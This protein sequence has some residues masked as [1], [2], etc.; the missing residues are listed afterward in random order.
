[1]KR[2]AAGTYHSVALKSDGTLAAW[3]D[4]SSGECNVP[5]GNNYVAVA[6][7]AYHSIALKSD[8]SLA[9]WGDNSLGECNV[10]GGNDYV[11][12]AVGDVHSVA[13]KTDGTLVA[14]GINLDGQCNVPGGNNYVAVAAAKSSCVALKTDGTLAAWGDNSLGQC[15][16]PDGNN[17][18]AVAAAGF[19][20]LALKSDG[21]L[22]AWGDNSFDLCNVPSG[23]NYVAVAG[24]FY[25]CVALKS[26]GTLAA[27]GDNSFGQCN[28]PSGL[29]LIPPET[30]GTLTVVAG[31]E[32]D[33]MEKTAGVDVIVPLGTSKAAAGDTVKLLVNG[34]DFGIPVVHTIT[35]AE[36]TAG[37]CTVTIPATAGGGWDT[38]GS[39]AIT[40]RIIDGTGPGPVSQALT[41]NL[42][43]VAPSGNLSINDGA[44]LTIN[45]VVKLTITA[46]GTGSGLAQMRFSNDN[47]NWSNWEPFASSKNWTLGD[48]TDGIFTVYVGIQDIAGNI[49]VFSDTI[50]VKVD[51]PVFT[52]AGGNFNSPFA[53]SITCTTPGAEIRYTTD[54]SQATE[55][56]NLYKGIPILIN[57]AATITAKAFKS[58]WPSSDPVSAVYTIISNTVIVQPGDKDSPA[59]ANLLRTAQNFENNLAVQFDSATL[60]LGKGETGK[61]SDLWLCYPTLIGYGTGQIPE[62]VKIV[63]AKLV[64]TVKG[65]K[66]NPYL[67]HKINLY[68]IS[69]PDNFGAPYFGESGLR[70]GLDYQ[71]RDHRPGRN[72]KWTNNDK[73]G[74]GNANIGDL[75]S[76]NTPVDT[77]EV[78]PAYFNEEGY[79]QIRL[80]V[81]E[82]IKSWLS[83]SANQGW[84]LSGDAA[85]KWS[86]DDGV[87]FYGITDSIIANRPKLEVTFLDTN[88]D[89]NPP[90]TVTNLNADCAGGQVSLSWNN[91]TD[92]DFRG[93]LILRKVGLIPTDPTD[94]LAVYDQP[95]TV[96]SPVTYRDTGLTNDQTYYYA[97]FTY[98]NL[99]N[100]SRGTSIKAIPTAG[101]RVPDAP[102]GL[103]V[104]LNG[105]ALTFNWTDQSSNEKWFL[106]EQQNG[107]GDFVTVAYPAANQQSFATTLDD[108]NFNLTPNTGYTYRISA[109]NNYGS[110]LPSAT[111]SLNTGAFLQSPADLAWTIISAGRVNVS[112]TNQA[113]DAT[114]YRVAVCNSSRE[115]LWSYSL[116]A[117]AESF[118]VTGL[119][120]GTEYL[121]KVVVIKG[122]ETAAI[123]T[124]PI[125]TA[126]DPKGGLL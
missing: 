106:L 54:G 63:S 9:A 28:I 111:Y 22:A 50:T 67:T 25:H 56:S 71:Y 76:G 108:P 80:D 115:E 92:N 85:D 79:T 33:L 95:G 29:D 38:D 1:M 35:A 19:C 61:L 109:V 90:G 125:I 105:N 91:P 83:G 98:D 93:V 70:N 69:D 60:W 8:G 99:R 57:S 49:S 21:T 10:P 118:S 107:T 75:I 44:S 104:G 120:P 68:Q 51:N 43:T 96:G 3:G 64:L 110:S 126:V 47:Q 122:I 37:S 40:A 20:G 88:A 101:G 14:W 65:F 82:S 6:A 121:I 119:K 36:I 114:G 55:I 87:E 103:T 53:V 31:P 124:E 39:K 32:I 84:F 15:N 123:W 42:D 24:G 16:V 46:D 81:T 73:N 74:D 5:G 2:I 48:S 7:G 116:A 102:Y 11:A 78:I 58:G 45:L 94:G 117:D 112:W 26:D 12:V 77:Y 30:P 89:N 86:F 52:P 34:T 41:L 4:N 23:N 66:G 113:L 100:Y 59:S 72:I 62:N 27:W 17:Y 13:L 97:V 18:V